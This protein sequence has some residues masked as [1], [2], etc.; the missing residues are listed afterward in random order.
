LSLTAPSGQAFNAKRIKSRSACMFV[1]TTPVQRPHNHKVSGTPEP[2]V[3]EPQSL[4]S[5]T[6]N[7]GG[8]G[9]PVNASHK[10]CSLTTSVQG[11]ATVEGNGDAPATPKTTT[12]ADR[13]EELHPHCSVAAE[14]PDDAG[15]PCMRSP[16]VQYHRASNKVSF[17]IPQVRRSRA[18]TTTNW[19]FDHNEQRG[20]AEK[21]Q[22]FTLDA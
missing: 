3:A 6:C 14:Q 18:M 19:M 15:G 22:P 8:A 21:T 17:R 11:T 13:S 10:R 2:A 16:Q 12:G 4:R 5:T 7:K 1:G 9:N 20:R